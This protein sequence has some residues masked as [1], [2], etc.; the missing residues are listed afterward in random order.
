MR[1]KPT[2]A[3]T[4]SVGI[5]FI[6]GLS[7]VMN[8]VLIPF[9]QG[10]FEMDF[11]TAS[12][13]QVSFF[14]AY[15][16]VSPLSGFF[17]SRMQHLHQIRISLLTGGIGTQTILIAMNQESYPLI[18]FGV[19]I[20][21]SGIAMAQVSINPYTMGLGDVQSGP[22]RLTIAQSFTS[23][24][25]MLAPFIGSTFLLTA[26]TTPE[27]PYRLLTYLWASLLVASFL[28]PLP[29]GQKPTS[30]RFSIDPQILLGMVAV[31]ICV[32]IEVSTSTYLVLFLVDP[33]IIGVSFLAAGNLSMIFWGGF[34][35][36]R[37]IGGIAMRK[38]PASTLLWLHASGGAILSVMVVFT[39]GMTAAVCI[40]GLGLCTSVMFPVIYSIVLSRTQKNQTVVTG[41]LCLAMVGGALA[42]FLQ[43]TLADHMGLQSSFMVIIAANFFLLFYAR[44]ISRQKVLANVSS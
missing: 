40:L 31:A 21:G 12:L 16:V 37:L 3:L 38:V 17:F 34:L 11:T 24:G 6:C 39:S 20:L 41:F 5:F 1:E 14:L 10:V 29:K 25:Q 32:G 19:F 13:V 43:G 23:L 2:V 35:I 7:Q 42:P 33:T 15:F 28:I 8:M 36:G 30:A 22:S 9:L 44:A 18:L 4:F 26:H 27:T